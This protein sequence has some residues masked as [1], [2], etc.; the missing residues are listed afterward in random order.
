MKNK[1]RGAT[2][3]GVSYNAQV[4]LYE[5]TESGVLYQFD[6]FMLDKL[7]HKDRTSNLGNDVNFVAEWYRSLP[8][9]EKKKVKRL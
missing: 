9:D 7:K 3:V 8:P 1:K 4:G 6:M 5:I 2:I